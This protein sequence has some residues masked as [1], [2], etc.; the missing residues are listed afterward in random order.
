MRVCSWLVAA[1]LFSHGIVPASAEVPNAGRS[2][3][4]LKELAAAGGNYRKIQEVRQKSASLIGR[5]MLGRFFGGRFPGGPRTENLQAGAGTY[6][7]KLIAE[8]ITLTGSVEVRLD[9]IL[10]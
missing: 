3:A 4:A 5:G 2:A 1:V 7:V 8:D 10:K 6:A 9:P